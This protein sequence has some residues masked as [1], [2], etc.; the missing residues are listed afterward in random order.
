MIGSWLHAAS[1]AWHSV[2]RT[3]LCWFPVMRS[4]NNC[5]RF[6]EYCF[7]LAL[8]PDQIADTYKIIK[9]LLYG[10][11]SLES[12]SYVQ[13]GRELVYRNTIHKLR[14][15]VVIYKTTLSVTSLDISF[16][17]FR[18]VN[19]EFTNVKICTS[20]EFCF[21]EHNSIK[22][23]IRGVHQYC[24]MVLHKLKSHKKAIDD[25]KLRKA[26]CW[27]YQPAEYLWWRLPH[28]AWTSRAKMH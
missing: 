13:S 11:F 21:V 19:R 25:S 3:G 22:E 8:V 16:N 14:V 15:L 2:W 12:R 27:I 9:Y 26:T 5:F 10:V 1:S 7:W 28:K 4:K 24:G 23:T 17:N 18:A 20:L 6:Q